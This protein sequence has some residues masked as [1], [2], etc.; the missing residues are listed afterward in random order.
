MED[1]YV[2]EK[3]LS[4]RLFKYIFHSNLSLSVLLNPFHWRFG[5]SLS[6]DKAGGMR[7]AFS[8]QILPLHLMLFIDDGDW[9]TFEDYYGM[10]DAQPDS[11][12]DNRGREALQDTG[13]P[14]PLVEITRDILR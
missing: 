14:R 13:A 10:S 5:M 1:R 4:V 6:K 12:P 11:V 9:Q 8:L 3:D 2:K 7:F